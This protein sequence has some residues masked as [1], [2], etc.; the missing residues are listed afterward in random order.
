LEFDVPFQHKYG[1]ITG[2]L[3]DWEEIDRLQQGERTI[4]PQKKLN[5]RRQN[6]ARTLTKIYT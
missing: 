5:Q 2:G 4:T 1:Y 6:E 3:F